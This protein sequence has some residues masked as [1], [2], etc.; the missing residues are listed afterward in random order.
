M[1]SYNTTT[2]DHDNNLSQRFSEPFAWAIKNIFID[3]QGWDDCKENDLPDLFEYLLEPNHPNRMSEFKKDLH[4]V[5]VN[6]TITPDDWKR[7]YGE[8]LLFQYSIN[9]FFVEVWTD[10]FPEEKPPREFQW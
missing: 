6:E 1:A 2:R 7:W 9:N 4:D 3:T 10:M 8:T 5:L